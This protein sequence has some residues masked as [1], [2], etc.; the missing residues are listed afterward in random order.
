[1]AK[2]IERKFLLKNENWKTQVDKSFTIKQGYLSTNPERTVRI[3]IKGKKGILTIKGI[4]KG[5]SR[6][7]Y[8]YEIPF[9]D[10]IELLDLCEQ[11][12]IEKERYIIIDGKLKWEI[13]I[14]EGINKGLEL[15]EV[16]LESEDQKVN[17]PNWIEKEVTS[18][19]RYYNSSLIKMPFKDWKN[20]KC[21]F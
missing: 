1:M 10:A 3:R 15:A 4:T 14:F 13:D 20:N 12:I 11:P 6:L 17:L 19:K 9:Q 18:D 7:E 21:S 8:E 2:E 5:I 16:E